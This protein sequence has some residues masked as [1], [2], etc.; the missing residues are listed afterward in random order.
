MHGQVECVKTPTETATRASVPIVTHLKGE[1]H[2]EWVVESSACCDLRGI[3]VGDGRVFVSDIWRHCIHVY[4]LEGVRLGQW[5]SHGAEQCQFSEPR[6]LAV[7]GEE[8][9]VCDTKNR[10]VQV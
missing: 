5:G 3:T 1:V 4:S 6:G 2:R 8:L 7:S 9:Y 10:R